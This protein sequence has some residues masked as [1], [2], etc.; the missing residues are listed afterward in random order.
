M[1]RLRTRAQLG[2]VSAVLAA[3]ALTVPGAAPANAAVTAPIACPGAFPTAQAVDGLVGTGFTVER[4][5][6]PQPFTAN[7]LGRITDGIAPGVDMIMA[8]VTSPAVDRAGGI[9]AGMSGSPVYSPDGRLIGAVAYGLVANSPIAGITPASDMK[10]LATGVGA[11]GAVKAKVSVG[12]QTAARIART[13]DVTAAAAAQGFRRLPVPVTVSG[14]SAAH[15]GDRELERTRRAFPNDLVQ[16]GSAARG[17][18]APADEI[19][20]GGNFAAALSYGTASLAGVGTTTFVCDDQAVAFGHPFQFTGADSKYSAHVA[21]SLFVQDNELGVPF[22]VANVGGVAGTVDQD[23]L[24]GIKAQ[25]GVLTPPAPITTNL[26]VDG[27]PVTT[28]KTQ[29]ISQ[30]FMDLITFNHMLAAVDRGID[31][32]GPGTAA[33]T[34]RVRGTR[35]NGSAFVVSRGDRL[36]STGDLSLEL[37]FKVADFVSAIVNQD[38][39]NIKITSVTVG[40]ALTTTAS[41]YRVTA[42]KVCASGRCINPPSPIRVREGGVLTT[43]L[44][45]RPYRGGGVTKNLQVKVAVP[46]GAGTNGFGDLSVAA[47]DTLPSFPEPTTF[48]QLLTQLRAAPSGDSIRLAMRIRNADTNKTVTTRVTAKADRAI[49][50]YENSF[51]VSIP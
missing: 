38:L 40:G 41:D 15:S 8:D 17:T 47:G 26:S 6:T 34:I 46:K 12:P 20:A 29:A 44:T 13:G 7:V 27:G 43:Q 19:K 49:Q 28:L 42:F 22:K 25:L 1:V 21:D 23:R 11:G 39:E 24:A 32:I 9:W 4:G 35:A 14:P 3:G 16:L 30:P 50:P 36:S 2:A 18:A 51:D 45:V 33:V 37:G 5:T 10:K 31:K 48:A